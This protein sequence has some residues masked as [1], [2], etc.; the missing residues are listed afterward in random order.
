[1]DLCCQTTVLSCLC[2]EVWYFNPLVL[3]IEIH[4]AM[5][6]NVIKTIQRKCCH[7]S[8]Q[9]S[10][11]RS[12]RVASGKEGAND[13]I[14]GYN[15]W[16]LTEKRYK[17]KC[18]KRTASCTRKNSNPPVLLSTCCLMSLPSAKKH[19]ANKCFPACFGRYKIVI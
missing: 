9:S 18:L 15:R 17:R 10:S 4:P 8:L 12:N 16:F 5:N 19:D 6:S 14:N 7:T 13:R 3:S 11:H 1:M 2:L